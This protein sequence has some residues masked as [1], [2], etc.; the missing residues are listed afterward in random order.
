MEEREP[1]NL[2]DCM[3]QDPVNRRRTAAG[4]L[5][6]TSAIV[7]FGV[8]RN[9][10]FA[11]LTDQTIMSRH[12]EIVSF[13]VSPELRDALEELADGTGATVSDLGRRLLWYGVETQGDD[14][15]DRLAEQT[16]IEKRIS[17]V[18]EQ[19]R[20]VRKVLP[21][22]W[23]SHVRDLFQ[24]DLSNE[25]APEG[26]AIMAKRY[27]EQARDLEELAETIPEAPEADLEAIVDEELAHAIEAAD[28][29]TWYENVDNPHE[30][31]LEGVREG[32]EERRD[33]AALVGSLVESHGQMLEAFQDREHAPAL[34]ASDLPLRA[35]S[36]LPE[37]MD[38]ED[39]AELATQLA[40]RGL[41]PDQAKDVVMS[42]RLEDVEDVLESVPI[43]VEGG[44]VQDD[45]DD[46]SPPPMLRM[47]GT[48]QPN[49]LGPGGEEQASLGRLPA[50]DG[51]RSDGAREAGWTDEDEQSDERADG[52]NP[53]SME[54]DTPTNDDAQTENSAEES[55]EGGE[56]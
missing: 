13:R 11:R 8:G 39:V 49:G 53:D 17:G 42:G 54:R 18:I 38:R 40:R 26:L 28:V 12:D 41:G 47:G 37:Q 22:R 29:S 30:R 50:A 25:V 7:R 16:E 34:S 9:Q 6:G 19:N 48:L 5:T 43:E 35:D 46:D 23:K 45:G 51:G 31:H 20:R 27:R 44:V 36:L 56:A 10:P 21:S 3:G 1:L 33:L 4:P 55:T 32:A 2:P 52:E 15:A 24:T 14:V